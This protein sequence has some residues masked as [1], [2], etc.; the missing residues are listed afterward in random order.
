MREHCKARRSRSKASMGAFERHSTL[1]MRIP[2]LKPSIQAVG[3]HQR[4]IHPPAGVSGRVVGTCEI[5][6]HASILR[7]GG[8]VR[9]HAWA[10]SNGIIP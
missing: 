2:R 8:R 5:G 3:E 7:R 9:G 4:R 6:E 1:D 10:R